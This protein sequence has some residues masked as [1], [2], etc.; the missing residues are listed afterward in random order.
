VCFYYS[1]K[2]ALVT[3]AGVPPSAIALS[4][5]ASKMQSRMIGQEL[6][7]AKASSLAT[8]ALSSIDTVKCF[9]S[10][11]SEVK[12]Y[13]FAVNKAA[14]FYLNQALNNG[15]QIGFVRF[16]LTSM[17]V[18]GF[19]YGSYLVRKG[20]TSTGT[21]ATTFWSALMATRAW[22]D[23]LQ[24]L[25]VL[26][27]DRAAA[28]ALKAILDNV[29]NGRKIVELATGI[30]PRFCKGDVEVRQVRSSHGYHPVLPC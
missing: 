15:L 26:E 7:I 10:Q 21:V 27:K 14:K 16:I 24:H 1:W 2:V 23:T 28:I 22:E 13:T 12:Q 17:F 8:N 4:V 11:D 6:E 25:N 30:T 18:Q 5:L 19:W 20:D 3:L 29:E 9:N